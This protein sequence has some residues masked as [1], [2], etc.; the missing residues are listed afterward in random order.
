[1]TLTSL[2]RS[3]RP[4]ALRKD[5]KGWV[6]EALAI[7]ERA[8]REA[9]VHGDRCTWLVRDIVYPK[10]VEPKDRPTLR[11]MK[12]NVYDGTAGVA[13]LLARLDSVEARPVFR[14]RALQ[15]LNHSLH[16]DWD[17]EDQRQ[18]AGYFAGLT[19]VAYAAHEL[20]TRLQRPQLRQDRDRLIAKVAA[21]PPGYP[22]LIFGGASA[23]P[24][25][26]RIHEDDPSCEPALETAR[27]MAAHLVETA[28]W[29]GD[30]ASWDGARSRGAHTPN[31]TGFS[32]GT[33]GIAWGLAQYARYDG[34]RDA[35]EAAEGALRYEALWF[36]EGRRNWRDLRNDFAPD[37]SLPVKFANVWCH[38]APGIGL[39]RL[40][41]ADALGL[42]DAIASDLRHAAERTQEGL[43]KWWLSP[44]TDVCACHGVAGNAEALALMESALGRDG[45]ATMREWAAWLV[46]R[47]GAAAGVDWPTA[48]SHGQYPA[49]VTGAGG[50]A[51]FL[52]RAAHPDLLEPLV[53]P[54]APRGVRA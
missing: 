54:P 38:G 17:A 14:E 28:Q 19:G 27:R 25:L 36:D 42:P 49:L 51:H 35:R 7:G 11:P 39:G 3:E 45:G 41:F 23:V 15:A 37:H 31:L 6:A 9:Y 18:A 47:Y 32:H 4:E 50:A 10:G 22:D 43:A 13:L 26:C 20:S 48:V 40:A 2:V 33:S 16:H 5:P 53:L 24:A 29:D 8:C 52:V 21:L 12:A 46:A 34:D 44:G 1:M 30:A